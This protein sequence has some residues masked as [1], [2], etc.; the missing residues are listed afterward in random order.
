MTTQTTKITVSLKGTS[1]YLKAGTKP[2]VRLGS[3]RKLAEKVEDIEAEVGTVEVAGDA[4]LLAAL[5]AERQGLATADDEP[6]VEEQLVAGGMDPALAAEVAAVELPTNPADLEGLREGLAEVQDAAADSRCEGCGCIECQCPPAGEPEPGT[7]TCNCEG[8]CEHEGEDALAAASEPDP[9]D[10]IA[11][12]P[13]LADEAAGGTGDRDPRLPAPGT[14]ITVEH[15]GTHGGRWEVTVEES[16]FTFN[17]QHFK[18]LSGVAK[19]ATGQSWNGFLWAGLAKRS[20][21]AGEPKGPTQRE[22]IALARAKAAQ[23]LQANLEAG[24]TILPDGD[25]READAAE[26]MRSLIDALLAR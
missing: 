18:S 22:V 15:K 20:T 19:A 17:G 3:L 26:A 12:N 5:E 11:D 16:G 8:P 13:D 14:V 10:A 23:W 1:Y 25:G 9:A 2:P 6:T 4:D 24:C 7:T 21:A